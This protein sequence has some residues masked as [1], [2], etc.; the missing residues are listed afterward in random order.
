[1][2]QAI[3]LI[4]AL[5]VIFTHEIEFVAESFA[6]LTSAQMAAYERREGKPTEV[7]YRVTEFESHAIERTV[8]KVTMEL[9]IVTESQRQLLLDGVAY[10]Y[11]ATKELDK[12]HPSF[13]ERLDYLRPRLPPIVTANPEQL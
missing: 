10:V 2:L 4:P 1:M 3:R 12:T 7:V 13:T 6:E 8:D 5:Q 9:S 11:R